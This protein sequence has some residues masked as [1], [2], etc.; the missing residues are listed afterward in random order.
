MNDIEE[1]ENTAI[2]Q[3]DDATDQLSTREAIELAV[4]DS[5]DDAPKA[6]PAPSI[7]QVKEAVDADIEPP[8]EFSSDAKKAWREKNVSAIQK[9]YTRLSASRLQELSR[10]QTSERLAREESKFAKELESIA[11]PYLKARGDQGVSAGQAIQEALALITQIKSSNPALV[12]AELKRIGIDLDSNESDSGAGVIP[13]EVQAK[14]DSFQ[15]FADDVTSEREQARFQNLAQTFDQVFLSLTAQKTRTNEP[16][17]PDL[18]DNSEKGIGFARELG[19]LT[20]KPDFQRGVLRRFPDATLDVF[21]REAYKYLGGKV[22]GE[23]VTVSTKTKKEHIDRSTRAAAST[24]SRQSVRGD[25]RATAGKF[26]TRE[27][28]LRAMADQQD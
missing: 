1:V 6:A 22:S 16:V 21:V 12:R 4:S 20:Q 19:S 18:L 23:P 15:K 11:S 27:S 28:I 25:P 3:A 26:S 5:S 9:E 10:A 24:P 2:E 14:L 17:F 13:K 7:R 8:S